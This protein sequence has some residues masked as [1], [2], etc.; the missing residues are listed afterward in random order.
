MA[1]Y[2]TRHNVIKTQVKD[3]LK[4]NKNYH[5]KFFINNHLQW[6]KIS[7]LDSLL[8]PQFKTLNSLKNFELDLL[9]ESY[10]E[11]TKKET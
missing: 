8:K 11:F 9:K 2:L 3:L 1:S 7:K 6:K 10:A 4:E 5:I